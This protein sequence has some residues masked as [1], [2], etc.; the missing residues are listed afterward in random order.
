MSTDSRAYAEKQ[1]DASSPVMRLHLEQVTIAATML[2]HKFQKADA[3]SP[4]DRVLSDLSADNVSCVA[5][6]NYGL[7]RNQQLWRRSA[8]G[9]AGSCYHWTCIK[10]LSKSSVRW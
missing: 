1:L 4:L 2:S 5:M 7:D 6:F 8:F 3:M 9:L 10:I